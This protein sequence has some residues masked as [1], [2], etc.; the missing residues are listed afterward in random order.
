ML[1]P[2]NNNN[3]VTQSFV[4]TMAWCRKRPSLTALEVLWRWVYGVPALLVLRYEVV[5]ILLATPLD[6]AGLKGMTLLDPMQSSVTLAKA[7]VALG[8]PVIAVAVWL[9][10]VLLGGWV[11]VS[12]LGRT[13]VLKRVDP[14]LHARPGTLMVLQAV[15]ML[16]LG[17]SFAVWLWCL[18]GAAQVAVTGPIA[19]GQEP[20]LVLYFALAITATLVLFTGWAVVSWVFSVAPLLAML[21]G[22]GAAR[23]LR[24]SFR[25]GGL[26]IK[27]VEINLVMAIVK[28][29]LIVLAMVFSASPL[30]FETV[31][32]QGFLVAWWCG[33]GVLYFVASD[34]FHVARLVAYLELWRAAEG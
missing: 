27:L 12:S 34:F 30:P 2:E 29:A 11:V 3:R 18:Q 20:S 16:A 25:L 5:K 15:R 32:T 22:W 1:L 24:A 8:P 17:V 4:G 13:V 31:A 28:V 14:A 23:S 19:A 10:P 21:R 33:V 26:K 7:L 6:Y 9:G